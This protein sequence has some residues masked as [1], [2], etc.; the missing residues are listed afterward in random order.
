MWPCCP[1]Y[2]L[3][4]A[5]VLYQLNVIRKFTQILLLT[6]ACRHEVGH[7]MHLSV[8]IAHRP[9][10]YY[11]CDSREAITFCI[12][13]YPTQTPLV[14]PELRA[15]RFGQLRGGPQVIVNEILACSHLT[16]TC[17]VNSHLVRSG[18]RGAAGVCSC[19]V[20]RRIPASY[21]RIGRRIHV[22]SPVGNDR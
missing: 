10:F 20:V 2:Y 19:A 5:V 16:H 8:C 12:H 7:V 14:D 22:W 4:L 9:A 15:C 17:D 6:Y 21:G 3:A 11:I 13:N 18:A 1:R